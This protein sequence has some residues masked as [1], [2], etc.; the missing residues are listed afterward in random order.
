[1]GWR[2]RLDPVT[3]AETA[4]APPPAAPRAFGA[5]FVLVVASAL[6][7]FIGLGILAPVLPRYVED[8]LNGGGAEVGIVVG[9]FA[10]TAALLRPAVGRLGDR[11]GR[12]VLVV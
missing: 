11:R 6:A 10:L 3:T 8:E 5:P 9:A 2:A 1:M 4:P 12:R 7:Y